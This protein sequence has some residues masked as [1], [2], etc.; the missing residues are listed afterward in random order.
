MPTI[1]NIISANRIYA[2]PESPYD[3]RGIQI[4]DYVQDNVITDNHL[5]NCVLAALVQTGSTGVNWRLGEHDKKEQ[6]LHHREQWNCNLQR[7]W[8]NYRICDPPRFS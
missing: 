1:S 8:N 7:R 4:H 6:G 3:I 2:E 5:Y